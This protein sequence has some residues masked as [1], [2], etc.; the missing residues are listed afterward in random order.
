MVVPGIE[1]LLM[2]IMF[3]VRI[4]RITCRKVSRRIIEGVGIKLLL[5]DWLFNC[6]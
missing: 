6:Y 3:R 4:I 1:T 5:D 2:L